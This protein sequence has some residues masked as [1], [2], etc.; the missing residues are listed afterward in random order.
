[1]GGSV[2]LIDGHIDEFESKKPDECDGCVELWGVHYCRLVG[3]P[4]VRVTECPE[5]RGGNT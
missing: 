3:M 2:S 4:C 5:G 1:M